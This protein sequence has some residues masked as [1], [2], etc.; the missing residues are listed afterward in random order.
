MAHPRV[1]LVD[2]D[3][4]V[5]GALGRLLGSKC[6][7]RL[8]VASSSLQALQYLNAAPF[9]LIVSDAALPG[10]NGTHLLALCMERWPDMRRAIYTGRK[11]W[12][13]DFADVILM[14][15]DDPKPIVEKLCALAYTPRRQDNGK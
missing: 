10:I 6:S 9:A 12:S 11:D 1:L 3:T 4:L 7:I 14:K 8:A 13:V 15:G 5:T 2:D